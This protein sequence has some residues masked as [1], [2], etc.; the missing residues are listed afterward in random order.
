MKQEIIELINNNF[1]KAVDDLMFFNLW[2]N[3]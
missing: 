3:S 1:R 2:I